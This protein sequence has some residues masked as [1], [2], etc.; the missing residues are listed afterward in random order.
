AGAGRGEGGVDGRLGLL[1]QGLGI[2][3]GLG[4]EVDGQVRAV[5]LDV[6]RDRGGDVEVVLVGEN[7]VGR[8]GRAAGGGVAQAGDNGAA[9]H[10]ADVAGDALAGSDDGGVHQPLHLG[11][12]VLHAA[13]VQRLGCVGVDREVDVRTVILERERQRVV[14]GVG[15]DEAVAAGLGDGRLG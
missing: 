2:G 1:A 8:G 13:V 11:D 9:P 10:H 3:V 7:G 15:D 4:R 6:D 5:V 12:E 14:G